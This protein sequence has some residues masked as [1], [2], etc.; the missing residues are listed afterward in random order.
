M[1]IKNRFGK[2]EPRIGR[3]FVAKGYGKNSNKYIIYKDEPYYITSAITI[4]FDVPLFDSM[5][6]AYSFL[7]NNLDFLV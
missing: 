7:K 6:Q 3:F 5:V 2:I 4:L 1:V